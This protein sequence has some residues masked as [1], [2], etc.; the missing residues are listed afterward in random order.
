MKRESQ[1]A[2]IDGPETVLRHRMPRFRGCNGRER[3]INSTYPC[4]GTIIHKWTAELAP[5]SPTITVVEHGVIWLVFLDQA[6][7]SA[8]QIT[9]AED[10]LLIEVE[11][12][13]LR[14][15]PLNKINI[16]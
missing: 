13:A 8:S 2:E 9:P 6:V 5:G 15:V 1:S 4:Q 16:L 14:V 12:G 10:S 7:W 11:I 3:E